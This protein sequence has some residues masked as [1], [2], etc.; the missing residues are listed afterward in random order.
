MLYYHSVD[1][2]STLMSILL[3][4]CSQMRQ[5]LVNQAL[6]GGDLAT[7]S[8]PLPPPLLPVKRP[9][10][11]H[12][13]STDKDSSYQTPPAQ[14]ISAPGL[15][16]G[17]KPLLPQ[18]HSN[19]SYAGG[20]TGGSA[21]ATTTGPKAA[22]L[23]AQGLLV[24]G[25]TKT[26][27][28][29]DP[30]ARLLQ[31]NNNNNKAQLQQSGGG[32]DDKK[33]NPVAGPAADSAW[34]QAI[35]HPKEHFQLTNPLPRPPQQQQTRLAV[36]PPLR[37]SQRARGASR[38]FHS[39]GAMAS[40]LPTTT[41]H[42]AS[43]RIDEDGLDPI[44]DSPTQSPI[45]KLNMSRVVDNSPKKIN[46]TKGEVPDRQV[47]GNKKK[48]KL[49]V[50][51]VA[52][53]QEEKEIDENN[54]EDNKVF[55]KKKEEIRD[56]TEETP[57]FIVPS[58]RP[59]PLYERTQAPH[60]PRS[61]RLAA[62]LPLPHLSESIPATP[63]GLFDISETQPE[64]GGGGGGEAAGPSYKKAK[65][66]TTSGATEVA[67]DAS[68]RLLL[69]GIFS[70]LTEP[71]LQ[72]R[73]KEGAVEVVAIERERDLE[74][75]SASIDGNG[76]GS[77]GLRHKV[78]LR[79]EE[80]EATPA[81]YNR[82]RDLS[83]PAAAAD[84]VLPTSGLGNSDAGGGGGGERQLRPTSKRLAHLLA[85]DMVPET[86]VDDIDIYALDETMN[87]VPNTAEAILPLSNGASAIPVA[88]T[89]KKLQ[90]AAAATAATAPPQT[91]LPTLRPFSPYATGYS[92]P[93]ST[94]RRLQY[95]QSILRRGRLGGFGG[96][97]ITP[98]PLQP[99]QSAL[100]GS[101]A[102]TG[103]ALSSTR[104]TACP[105]PTAEEPLSLKLRLS[106][107]ALAVVTSG[108]GRFMAVLLGSHADW[109][110]N[111]VLV[112][113]ICLDHAPK[114]PV[115]KEAAAVVVE[116]TAAAVAAMDNEKN[117]AK[118][119]ASISVQRSH[120]ATGLP[121]TPSSLALASTPKGEPILILSGVYDLPD[122]PASLGR[123]TIH[124]VH[125]G[126]TTLTT[127][128]TTCVAGTAL[129]VE[130]DDP[131][132]SIAMLGPHTLLAVGDGSSSN[133][134]SVIHFD[135]HWKSYSWGRSL[136]PAIHSSSSS[137]WC[138]KNINSIDIGHA[139]GGA[140]GSGG[141]AIGL[142]DVCSLLITPNGNSDAIN[143]INNSN[144]TRKKF[145][146]RDS[147]ASPSFNYIITGMSAT[148][149]VGSWKM[150]S[151]A[152]EC[153][154]TGSHAGYAVRAAIPIPDFS[155]KSR[156]GDT[157]AKGQ[158]F[159]ALL[160]SKE[161]RIGETAVALAT[162]SPSGGLALGQTVPIPVQITAIGCLEPPMFSP[163]EPT[164]Q[165]TATTSPRSTTNNNLDKKRHCYHHNQGKIVLGCG[166]GTI[167]VWDLPTGVCSPPFNVC[168]GAA[169]TSFATTSTTST[170]ALGGGNENDEAGMIEAI[171][172]T[173]IAGDCVLLET[174]ALMELC[175]E[176]SS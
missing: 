51:T 173:S 162:L 70:P 126:A 21:D 71:G 62:P 147:S 149:M 136:P 98:L 64:G 125:C 106:Q 60:G 174:A 121:I 59:T 154:T 105:L 77:D 159:V 44:I 47:V 100:I 156:D 14:K 88:T 160:Q 15:A 46:T 33:K 56:G 131:F 40:A 12:K 35:H 8:N 118:V 19:D 110:P 108:D 83:S 85:A 111:E 79:C 28:N 166:D 49:D 143:A 76:N 29:T 63:A 84:A 20:S 137:I 45:L 41:T 161:S 5:T 58:T 139:G 55:G 78:T 99:P 4:Y 150:G 89:G 117:A 68:N 109:E 103:V 115:G 112:F 26:Q 92:L 3:T 61:R 1:S 37:R 16:L 127:T 94:D 176:S 54:E 53:E 11:I 73:A 144:N 87:P 152:A 18:L 57:F 90:S 167:R 31:G 22:A 7:N 17:R 39:S 80:T 10:R 91:A 141:G 138:T 65:H 25:D 128:D 116:T 38:L 140:S 42:Q 95:H 155:M 13:L 102:F 134:A 135:K 145:E 43:G 148:G 120:H 113:A 23:T 69:P 130:S 34:K 2:I 151:T 133:G 171:I 93:R 9:A 165:E 172:C 52:N 72:P 104:F 96:G 119:V 123:P 81:V 36:G 142:D 50:H 74:K 169:I 66:T 107:P 30:L 158:C 153:I 157:S 146:Q 132:F 27:P 175:T 170:A 168:C 75:K 124:A 129:G 24:S 163:G 97:N 114:T 82:H 164:R 122:G 32:V 67:Q 48:R 101:R 86:A 6:A